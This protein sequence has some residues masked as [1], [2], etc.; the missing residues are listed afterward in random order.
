[1]D[2]PQADAQ[3]PVSCSLVVVVIPRHQSDIPHHNS[4]SLYQSISLPISL[5]IPNL[6][7]HIANA[8]AEA[9]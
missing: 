6:Q 1:M 5:S 9:R 8:L 3:Q 7:S 4:P 2:I